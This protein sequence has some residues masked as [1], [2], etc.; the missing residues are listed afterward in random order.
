MNGDDLSAVAV[1]N[2]PVRRA[3]YEY[4]VAQGREVGRN[5]AAEAAG[6]QRTLAAFHLDKL[7][8]AGLLESGFKR[9]GERTG[10]GSG[11]PAKV[12]RRAPGEWQVSVPSRDYRTLALVLAEAVDLLGGDERAE[13][14][15][16][17]AGRRLAGGRGEPGPGGPGGP[18][19]SGGPGGQDPSRGR[20]GAA[21]G[22][23]AA[24][25][26][27]DSGDLDDLLR[28]RGYEPYEEDGRLRLRNCPFHVLAEEHP[29]LVCSMNLALCRGLLEGLGRDPGRARSD[30]RP[31]ECC[32][33]FSIDN[34]N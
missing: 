10:P 7:V 3:V 15:A 27:G 16:R 24:G 18:G 23:D 9:L 4:V 11:R 31:R 32:V 14:A 34:D 6:V 28:R 19:G 25:V 13:E 17:R 2:D 1:L 12:Y 33:S 5:E 22:P 21:G 20:E 26:P 29:L 30:P 8:E